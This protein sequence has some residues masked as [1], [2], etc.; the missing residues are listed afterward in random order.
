[1]PGALAL[2]GIVALL[3]V[4]ALLIPAQ[5]FARNTSA[6]V[7]P[8]V[9]GLV[10]GIGMTLIMLGTYVLPSFKYRP[11]VEVTFIGLLLLVLIELALLT[12]LN[13]SGANW[14]D[15]HRLAL[16]I[17]FL[18]F[19]LAFGLLQDFKSVAGRSLVSVITLWQLRRLWLK[20][21]APPETPQAA[22]LQSP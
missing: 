9:F 6:L 7:S 18:A 22:S 19:F 8:R 4:V 21:S 13:N 3:I 11:P 16:V 15:R 10:G 20:L 17:G 2:I 5:P 14:T 1:M 12:W